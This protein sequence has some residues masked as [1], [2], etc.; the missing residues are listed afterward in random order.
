MKIVSIVVFVTQHSNSG[1]RHP[2]CS[3]FWW[4]RHTHTDTAGVV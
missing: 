2:H 1:T 3:S 4:H